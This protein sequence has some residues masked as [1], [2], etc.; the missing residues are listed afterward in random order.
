[1]K[2]IGKRSLDYLLQNYFGLDSSQIKKL[3]KI[4]SRAITIFKSYPLTVLAIN[5]M[6]VLKDDD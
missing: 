1:M 4:D 5:Q 3:K 2:M 6:F